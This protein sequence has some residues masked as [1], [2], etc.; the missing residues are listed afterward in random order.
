LL[1][2]EGGHTVRAL[3]NQPSLLPGLSVYLTA[4][5]ELQYDRNIGFS[6]GPIP[7]SSVIKWCNLHDIY[8][9]TDIDTFLR[10]I[11]ALENTENEIENK[12]EK[13]QT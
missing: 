13:A 8:D 7:W 1:I 10:Y 4:Y 3:E 2:E 9:I 12:K 6:A 11:R 5:N